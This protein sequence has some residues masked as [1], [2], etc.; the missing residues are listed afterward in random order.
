MRIFLISILL[1]SLN[2]SSAQ[3]QHKRIFK[4]TEFINGSLYR[5]LYDTIKT[6]SERM[7]IYFLKKH[8]YS[9]Y[10]LPDQFIDKQNRNKAISI[11][12]YPEDK[13]DFKQN[14]EYVYTYDSL[15]RVIRYT[16]SS[17]IICSTLPYDYSV[18]YNSNDQVILIQETVN[19]VTSFKFYY[20]SKGDIIKYEKY[21]GDKLA[22]EIRLVS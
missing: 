10:Y 6:G 20:N 11:W 12:R 3:K 9:P 19:P 14:W 15:G 22:L 1:L 8:F 7:D 16:Y 2:C 18:T 21:L 13:K 4:R 5:E 17:C